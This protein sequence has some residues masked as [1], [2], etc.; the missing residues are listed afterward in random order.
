MRVVKQGLLATISILAPALVLAQ[1]P[2]AAQSQKNVQVAQASSDDNVAA[3][4]ALLKQIE[5]LQVYNNLLET[6]IKNQ[7]TQLQDMK[8]A[9]EQA[10][11]FERQVPPLLSRM[12]DGLKQFVSLDIP[13]HP[14]ER[15]DRIANLES[16]LER[17]DITDAEKLRRI[18]QAWEVEVQ[19]GR[20]PEAYVGELDLD[21]KKRQVEYLRLGRVA[22]MYQ[23]TDAQAQTGIWDVNTKSWKTLSSDYHNTVHKA[24]QMARNQVAPALVLLPIPAPKAD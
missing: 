23:T 14:K 15:A 20:T 17:S 8:D 1:S 16:M 19:Y 12:I 10:P 22:W 13:F 2:Q 4:D 3:Y 5:G 6:Q 11:D 18:M 24:I 21:G 7:Q 9:I